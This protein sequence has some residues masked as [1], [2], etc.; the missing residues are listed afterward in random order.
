MFKNDLSQKVTLKGSQG[1]KIWLQKFV[2]VQERIE[3]PLGVDAREN[4][5][6]RDISQIEENES[7]N[8]MSHPTEKPELLSFSQIRQF[9]APV[10]LL[11]V[12]GIQNEWINKKCSWKIWLV[13]NTTLKFRQ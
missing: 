1:A 3:I 4:D 12:F 2:N 11:F 6:D 5:K 9:Y 7:G 13:G 8:R 10:T